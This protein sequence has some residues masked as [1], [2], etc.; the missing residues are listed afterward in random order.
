M[1]NLWE[2]TRNLE[3]K[4]LQHRIPSYL[5]LSLSFRNVQ[6]S[7]VNVVYFDRK[8]KTDSLVKAEIVWNGKFVGRILSFKE[9]K[10]LQHRIPSYLTFELSF[11]KVWL[12][13]F[14]VKNMSYGD[15]TKSSGYWPARFFPPLS[16]SDK[17]HRRW[18]LNRVH[19]I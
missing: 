2:K 3:S 1:A 18:Q 9:P 5:T 6:I 14:L 17:S 8:A 15:C 10:F 13:R 11:K 19:I 12:F 4:F 16:F 7:K